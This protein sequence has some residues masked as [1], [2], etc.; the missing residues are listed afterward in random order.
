MGNDEMLVATSEDKSSMN[1]Y[2]LSNRRIVA[3]LTPVE[4][5]K[6]VGMCMTIRVLESEEVLP[7]ILA[8]YENGSI[9]LWDTSTWKECTT[10]KC[11]NES[12]MAMDFSSIVNKGFSVT[13]LDTIVQWEIKDGREIKLLNEQKITNPGLNCISIRKDG[14]LFATGGWDSQARLFG[15]KKMKPLAVLSY[16]SASIQCVKF[17]D[18]NTLVLGSKDGCISFWSLYK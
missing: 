5:I 1:I 6:S 4:D 8:G 18:D 3:T 13:A 7:Q 2:S 14:K 12:V 11:H 9:S 16:H 17:L 10:L 15:C